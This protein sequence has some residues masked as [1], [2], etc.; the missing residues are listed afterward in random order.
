MVAWFIKRRTFERK[1]WHRC[2]RWTVGDAENNEYM[3]V[4]IA[5]VCSLILLVVFVSNFL[6]FQQRFLRHD[7]RPLR[8]MSRSNSTLHLYKHGVV[9]AV[10]RILRQ[11]LRI[12]GIARPAATLLR[13]SYVV[14]CTAVRRDH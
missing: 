1:L 2:F 14:L 4:I 3:A 13:K 7:A 12:I 10:G 9:T 5:M 8:E 11:L 6:D